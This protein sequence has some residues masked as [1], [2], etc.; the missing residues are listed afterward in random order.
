M[1]PRRILLSFVR[2]VAVALLMAAPPMTLWAQSSA[3]VSTYAELS[4]AVAN[5]SVNN[6][7]VTANIDVPCE[8]SGNAGDNDL[9]GVSTAQLIINRSLTLQSQAGSKFIVKR[10]SAN[11]ANASVL[12]S[13]IAIRGNG[14]GNSGT[15]NL[16]ETL[17]FRYLAVLAIL[18]PTQG[19]KN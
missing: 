7:V 2:N 14:H 6:I 11:D 19:L 17:S 13:M 8:T 10:V 4:A 16:A 15:D 12:K 3:Y 18:H 5:A 9:T 1:I